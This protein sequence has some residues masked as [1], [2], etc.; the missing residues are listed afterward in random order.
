MWKETR[1]EGAS[2]S[3]LILSD[4]RVY[5]IVFFVGQNLNSRFAFLGTEGVTVFFLFYIKF[6]N[7]KYI[8]TNING[9]TNSTSHST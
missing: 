4:W 8:I 6:F 2:R 1:G 7:S 3:Y 9:Q 5:K